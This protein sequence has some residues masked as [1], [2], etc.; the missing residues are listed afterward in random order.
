M[1]W[2]KTAE[3]HIFIIIIILIFNNF[4]LQWDE[5]NQYKYE[6]GEKSNT[7]LI[8]YLMLCFLVSDIT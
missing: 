7:H 8:L 6:L 1:S 3:K 4:L 2:M 5:V